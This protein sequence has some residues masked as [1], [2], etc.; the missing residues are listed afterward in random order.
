MG[1]FRFSERDAL[2]NH[3]AINVRPQSKLHVFDV[4][5]IQIASNT[6]FL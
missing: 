5:C 1:W 3:I 4:F 6:F 2:I